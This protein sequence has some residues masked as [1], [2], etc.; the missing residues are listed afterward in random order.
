MHSEVYSET[1][2]T[3]RLNSTG[4]LFPSFS[5]DPP[6]ADQFESLISGQ[7]VIPKFYIL[8]VLPSARTSCILKKC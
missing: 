7:P 3:R 5:H 1:T 4:S 6:S 8:L 2:G